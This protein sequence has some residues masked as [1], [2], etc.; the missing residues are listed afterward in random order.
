MTQ[1]GHAARIN[2]PTTEAVRQLT[3]G[4]KRPVFVTLSLSKGLSYEKSS[5]KGEL[6]TEELVLSEII[7][8]QTRK[9]CEILQTESFSRRL[10]S[11]CGCKRLFRRPLHRRIRFQ[12]EL[13]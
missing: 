13:Q 11:L 3:D 8:L 1:R 9:H 7:P 4:I 2:V 6:K 5:P 12:Q 10:L